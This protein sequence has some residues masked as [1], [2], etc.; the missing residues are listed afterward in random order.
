MRP[1]TAPSSPVA[2]LSASSLGQVTQCTHHLWS[3]LIS[4]LPLGMLLA[5]GGGD[6]HTVRLNKDRGIQA[7][8]LPLLRLPLLLCPVLPVGPW[9]STTA[10]LFCKD[11]NHTSYAGLA[12]AATNPIKQCFHFIG[13]TP[14]FPDNLRII[15]TAR[16]GA[17]RDAW[18]RGGRDAVL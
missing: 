2:A 3:S 13:Q 4:C 11:H 12:P 14:S 8:A 1:S 15:D 18:E 17:M 16:I 5:G 10:L 9:P 7:L 6:L